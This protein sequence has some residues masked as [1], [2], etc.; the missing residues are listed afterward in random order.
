MATLQRQVR[1]SHFKKSMSASIY[2]TDNDVWPSDMTLETL[3]VLTE[4]RLDPC[5]TCKSAYVYIYDYIYLFM[6]I[7]V[8][9]FKGLT[10]YT[11]QI[12]SFSY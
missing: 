8:H 12:P 1:Q 6:C 7:H 5:H 2:I 3:D 10:S 9:S 11:A 4:Y